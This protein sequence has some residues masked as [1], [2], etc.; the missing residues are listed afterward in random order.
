MMN[1]K[2]ILLSLCALV[3]ATN[4]TSAAN[5]EN[6]Q[7]RMVLEQIRDLA[8]ERGK[9]LFLDDAPE[10]LKYALIKI[11]AQNFAS[12]AQLPVAEIDLQLKTGGEK[13]ALKFICDQSFLQK[14]T[15]GAAQKIAELRTYA[16]NNRP[17]IL[18]MIARGETAEYLRMQVSSLLIQ[19]AHDGILTKDELT[20]AFDGLPAWHEKVLAFQTAYSAE[21][22]TLTILTSNMAFAG[23]LLQNQVPFSEVLS[24]TTEDEIKVLREKIE[25]EMRLLI[26]ALTVRVLRVVPLPPVI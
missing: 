25:Q 17:I 22:F 8:T 23:L 19:S 5:F 20:A 24:N 10:A 18:G 7:Q 16:Q 15:L 9:L 13:A 14:Y 2:S 6:P 3:C 26:I 21:S 12:C 11:L 1:F 4:Y